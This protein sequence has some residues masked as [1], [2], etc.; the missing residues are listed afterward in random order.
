MC[1]SILGVHY[2]ASL[3]AAEPGDTNKQ[4]VRNGSASTESTQKF[5]ECVFRQNLSKMSDNKQKNLQRPV[6]QD[7]IKIMMESAVDVGVVLSTYLMYLLPLQREH[8]LG[9]HENESG[10]D[11]DREKWNRKREMQGWIQLPTEN[12]PA[13]LNEKRGE[14]G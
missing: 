6:G 3:T 11:G 8:R 14:D 4:K 7:H 1:F 13:D 5:S 10:K 12:L 2:G 9:G